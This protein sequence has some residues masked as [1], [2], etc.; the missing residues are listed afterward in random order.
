MS[1]VLGESLHRLGDIDVYR[2]REWDAC[3]DWYWNWRKWRYDYVNI[4][5]IYS[6]ETPMRGV[7]KLVVKSGNGLVTA[8]NENRKSLS[9]QWLMQRT[10]PLWQ[11]L[12]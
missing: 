5:K 4:A 3:V 1:S 6:D 11:V 12:L 7:M 10:Y 8:S 2:Q 9:N